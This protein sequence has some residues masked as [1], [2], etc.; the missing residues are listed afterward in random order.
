M[1]QLDVFVAYTVV[2]WLVVLILLIV[3]RPK[4]EA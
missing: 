4:Q 3:T 1:R 2:G